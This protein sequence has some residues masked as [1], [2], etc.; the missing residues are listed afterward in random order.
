[1]YDFEMGIEDEKTEQESVQENEHG[2]MRW[3]IFSVRERVRRRESRA[4]RSEEAHG[5]F[6][7]TQEEE[8]EAVN[9][10]RWCNILRG[11]ISRNFTHS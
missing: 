3:K 8:E 6:D 2:G 9:P 10:P 11:C 1:M 4:E 5:L 7:K